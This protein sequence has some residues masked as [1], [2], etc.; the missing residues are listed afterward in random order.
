MEES[1]VSVVVVSFNTQEKLRRCLGCI[2]AHHELIVVDN[3]SHDGSADMVRNEFP[4]VRLI[5][6]TENVGF[7]AANN[8]GWNVASRDLVLFLNSDAYAEAGAIDLLAAEISKEG[9]IAGGGKLLNL[10]GSLQQSTARRLT[11]WAVLCEQTLLERVFKS[12][13][14]TSLLAADDSVKDTPQVM[15]ACLMV[16]NLPDL[17]WDERYFL[18]CEDTDL[19]LRLS[20]QGRIV[21][22]PA[23]RFTHDL[24]SSSRKDPW[25]GIARYNAGKELYFRI[26]HGRFAAWMCFLM[27]RLGALLRLLVWTILIPLKGAAQ[28]RTF[29]KV[30]TAPKSGPPRL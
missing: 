10:D 15:G 7:S 16:H 23:A 6:N 5:A 29:W 3:A 1:K 13:W 19:C 20:Q 27:D 2:E 9:V 12:Y 21:Y 28:A 30:L 14:T 25:K 11:L 8:Q 17:R 4:N 22:V 18:Y 26:Y 24:G